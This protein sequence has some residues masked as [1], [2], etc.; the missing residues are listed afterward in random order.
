MVACG[1]WRVFGG[2][3]R[4]RWWSWVAAKQVAEE[5]RGGE[6]RGESAGSF[7]AAVK[8]ASWIPK[9]L[10]IETPS[11]TNRRTRSS[12]FIVN[13]DYTPRTTSFSLSSYLPILSFS[14][15]PPPSF[16]CENI[17]GQKLYA[18]A[19]GALGH[20]ATGGRVPGKKKKGREYTEREAETERGKED[21][22]IER[23]REKKRQR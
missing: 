17:V 6:R 15:T 23:N 5:C 20:M 13:L 3:G 8:D 11:R 1:E 19:G 16:P 21:I 14:R 9:S 7:C 4:S 22:E 12:S 18:I 2:G 10:L